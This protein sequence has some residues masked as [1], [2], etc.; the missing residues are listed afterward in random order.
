MRTVISI[1]FLSILMIVSCKET[2]S[3]RNIETKNEIID[4]NKS[5]Q[6][7]KNNY[8]LFKK[9]MQEDNA[10]FFKGLYTK[11]A[12]FYTP[13]KT[14][15]GNEEIRNSFEKM[16]KSGNVIECTPIELDFYES[17]AFEIGQAKITN[18]SGELLAKE[19]YIVI[20]KKIGDKWK[21]H[22]DI[23]LKEKK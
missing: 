14:L 18:K 5:A 7:I 2:S 6:A 12:V 19:R 1:I 22:R 17:T 3:E 11:N 9:A 21:I 20:W 8:A 10:D 16:I 23:P 15:K 13:T 4:T